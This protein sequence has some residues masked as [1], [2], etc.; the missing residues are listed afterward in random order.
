MRLVLTG[1]MGSG[2]TTVGREVAAR[3]GWPFVDL[4]EEIEGSTGRSVREIFESSGEAAFR[5]LEREALH[6]ALA[7][8]PLVLAAGGGTL[9]D[10]ENLRAASA[11]GLVAWLHPAFDTIVR[12]V[13]G[14]GKEDRPMFRDEAS[15]LA[16]YRERLPAYAA[17]DVTIEIS[18]SESPA[19]VASRIVLRLRERGCTT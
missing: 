8:D 1:F 18:A 16:L 19:E 17:S 9:A 6:R 14:R 11:G 7:A 12:R 10:P 3:L 15:A 2:K 13:G 5:V 4:D